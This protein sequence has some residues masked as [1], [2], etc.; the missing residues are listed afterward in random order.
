MSSVYPLQQTFE[1]GVISPRVQGKAETEQYQNA[2]AKCENWQLKP[3]GSMR[4]RNGSAYLNMAQGIESR[5]FNF[6]RADR[7][8]LMV[9]VGYSKVRMYNQ[10]GTRTTEGGAGV[11]ILRDP[12]F[13]QGFK[14]WTRSIIGS[15]SQADGVAVPTQGV[16]LSLKSDSKSI[17]FISIEQRTRFNF[18]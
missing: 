8:D 15:I 4:Y 9:E 13:K 5:L 1:I 7:E 14:E 16:D 12:T 17:A 3:Q 11:N 18:W 10:D 2:L 6:S